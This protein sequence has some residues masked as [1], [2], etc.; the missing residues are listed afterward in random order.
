MLR[1]RLDAPMIAGMALIL[2]SFALLVRGSLA[3]RGAV[4]AT[5]DGAGYAFGIF[6][7]GLGF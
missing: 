1:E 2:A 6:S 7:G 3:Q 5:I 4:R